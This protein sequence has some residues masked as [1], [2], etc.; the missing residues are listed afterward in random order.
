MARFILFNFILAA[1]LLLTIVPKSQ[2]EPNT[3]TA[4]ASQSTQTT[5]TTQTTQ[6]QPITQTIKGTV[7]DIQTREPLIGATVIIRDS[8]PL[9]GASTDAGG[10]FRISGVPLGR[11][12]LQVNYVGYE[13]VI[14]PEVMA[15]SG[16]EVVV[17]VGLRESIAEMGEVIVTPEIRKNKPLNA[18]ATVSSRSFSVEEARRYAGGMDDPARLVSAFAGVAVGN[19]QDNAIIVRG[20]SPKGISWRVEGVEIPTPHHL[21]GG[22]VAGG[23][24][25]TIFSSHML[26]NSDFHTS[27]FPAEYGNALAGV[28]DMNLR[29]GNSTAHQHTFQAGTLGLDVASEGPIV[30][31]SNAS[32]LFNY[33][34]STLGLLTDLDVVPTDQEF[35][36]QDLSFKFNLPTRNAG[37][38]SLWGLGGIDRMAQPLETNPLEWENDWDRVSFDWDIQMGAAGLSHRLLTGKRT[39]V[40]TTLAATGTRNSM[41]TIRQD[42]DLVP[43]DDLDATDNSGKLS[44]GSYISHTFSPRVS[45]KTGAT[46]KR[47]QY[48]LAMSSTIDS[49]PSTYRDVI[50]E[51]GSSHEVEFYSQWR[52]DLAQNLVLNAGVNSGYFA[53]NEAFW[54][55]PRVALRY[56]LNDR[57]SLSL[58][59]G[60]HSQR[61]ELKIYLVRAEASRAAALASSDVRASSVAHATDDIQPGSDALANSDIQPGPDAL[62]NSNIHQNATLPNRD[63][64]LSGAHHFVLA[65]DWQIS[66]NMRMKVEPYAQFLF[67]APGIADSSFSMINYKQDWFFSDILENNSI[68][69]NVGLDVTLERF[70]HNGYYFLVTGSVFSS[71]YKGGDGVWRNTRFNKGYV[72][73]ALVGRE[74]AFRDGRRILGVNTRVNVAGG[75][76]VSPVL[77]EKSRER[78]LVF[79]DETRAFSNQLPSL[80]YAD[81]SVTLRLNRPGYSSIWA[82]QVKNALGRAMPEGYN[83]SYRTGSVE[84]DKSVVVVPSISYTIEF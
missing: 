47:L 21:P 69:R 53:L 43:H 25:V 1:F 16:R 63:L 7:Y 48:N 30:P 78:E 46:V 52:W 76:R 81:L 83:Y 50:D 51:S 2:S 55:D 31:G 40:S 45:T 79:F 34:Y 10:S 49:D 38:F 74:F 18:M 3:Q 82:V 26:D 35:R 77:Q 12:A 4:Q 80:L 44:L 57:H 70:L 19:V 36:Y 5:Q 61:E 72:A 54:V 75:E 23:G 59:Y 62:A 8:E 41:V 6:S 65:W 60:R 71:R 28:F 66:D 39:Y 33:R 32:Y 14:I 67:D 56:D 9:R 64:R 24:V 17:D 11:H 27:A 68:G 29:T 13:P 73:N 42:D 15:T 22:N 84:L 58:G 37:T 20:N